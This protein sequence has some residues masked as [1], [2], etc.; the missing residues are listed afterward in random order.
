MV[1]AADGEAIHATA[2][3]SNI[4]QEGERKEEIMAALH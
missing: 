1:K 3:A 2:V 4:A